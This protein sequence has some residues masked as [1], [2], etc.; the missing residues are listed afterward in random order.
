MAGHSDTLLYPP[1]PYAPD[2]IFTISHLFRLHMSDQSR[3]VFSFV[4]PDFL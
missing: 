2:G 1:D 3:A 4:I